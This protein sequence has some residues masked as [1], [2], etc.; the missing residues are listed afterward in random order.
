MITKIIESKTLKALFTCDCKCKFDGRKYNSNQRWNND[1]KCQW[2]CKNSV[3]HCVCKKDW[4]VL[5]MI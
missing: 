4:K 5:L 3:K 2:E 1:N